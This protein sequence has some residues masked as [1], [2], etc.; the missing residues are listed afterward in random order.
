MEC[1]RYQ[2]ASSLSSLLEQTIQLCII[3]YYNTHPIR[4]SYIQSAGNLLNQYRADSISASIYIP[5]H[6]H[7]P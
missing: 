2:T 5:A 3:T 4:F 1:T 7:C 6:C